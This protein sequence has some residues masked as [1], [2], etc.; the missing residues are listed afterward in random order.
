MGVK[1]FS[2]LIVDLKD[3]KAIADVE[4]SNDFFVDRCQVEILQDKIGEFD[5]KITVSFYDDKGRET[6]I[7][8]IEPSENLKKELRNALL[9][10]YFEIIEKQK[11]GLGTGFKQKN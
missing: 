4:L 11:T 7:I 8:N 3:V 1:V 2:L 5:F 6:K 9:P 10:R